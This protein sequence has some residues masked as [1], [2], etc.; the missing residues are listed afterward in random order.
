MDIF[1]LVGCIGVA[2]LALTIHETAHAAVADRFGDPTARMLGRVTLNPL[3]H[4]DPFMTILLP[5]ALLMMGSSVVFGGAKPVPVNLANFRRP[6]RD[7]AV[8]A[9]AG[10][11]SNVVQAFFWSGLLS[12]LLHAGVWS[13]QSAGV[14]IL[15]FAIMINAVLFVL[16]M[17]PLP[18]L[19][20]SRIVAAMLGPEARRGYLAIEPI[21]IFLLLALLFVD[22]FKLLLWMG[23]FTLGEWVAGLTRLP[24]SW[25]PVFG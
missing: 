21:G 4:I 18:P 13:E 15:Q 23:V 16:N 6:W 10:P 22:Q 9:F 1:V 14:T 19:D 3:P 8:V 7:N 11:A 20:G 17:L 2:I 24:I 12:I 5:A 25:I